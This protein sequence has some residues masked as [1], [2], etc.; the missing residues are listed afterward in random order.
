MS[1]YILLVQYTEGSPV[2]LCCSDIQRMKYLAATEEN[3]HLLIEMATRLM[4]QGLCYSWQLA[5]FASN[6]VFAAVD[7]V[8][9]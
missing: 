9:G 5:Q 8:R 7:G 1:N 3:K 6:P 4:E 2:V